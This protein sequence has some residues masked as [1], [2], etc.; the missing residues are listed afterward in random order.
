MP[1]VQG[2]GCGS[3]SSLLQVVSG[4]SCDALL[5]VATTGSRPFLS[6]VVACLSVTPPEPNVCR[7]KIR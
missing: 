4:W 2:I 1:G 3:H 6:E 5:A 7:D